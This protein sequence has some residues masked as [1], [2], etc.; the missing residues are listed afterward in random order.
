MNDEIDPHRISQI[1]RRHR[2]CFDGL[3][4]IFNDIQSAHGYLPEEALRIVAA[5]TG[6]SMVD[7]YGVATFYRS[8]SLK[9]RGK[10]IVSVCLGTA[11]HVRG[12]PMVLEEME[13]RLGVRAGETTAD[14]E[15]TL[16]RV[17][18]L[19]ACALGPI[20]AV[21]GHFF[22]NVSPAKVKTIIAKVR[23]GLERDAS[24]SRTGSAAEQA[25]EPANLEP[26]GAL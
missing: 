11:C 17:N 8:F 15:F 6:R 26:I 20:V 12:G 19:G 18:C 25:V 3:V 4:S 23:A 7:L 10:H 5:E 1:V 22:A 13:R 21:D 16:E 24:P 9:P 2:G 14:G